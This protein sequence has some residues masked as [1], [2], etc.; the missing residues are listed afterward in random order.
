MDAPTSLPLLEAFSTVIFDV[1]GTLV[2]S[3]AAHAETWTQAFREHG[4][5]VQV[6]R[7]RSMVGMGSDKLLPAIAAVEEDSARGRAI[8]HRKKEL[9]AGRMPM[10]NATRGARALVSY[11]RQR[12]KNVV[13]ATSADDR[14][15]KAL[16]AQAGVADLMP[17]RAS[18]DDAA[19]SKPDPDIVKAALVESG[20]RANRA[21]MIGDTPYDVEA[22]RRAG[23]GA[24][25]LRCGGYWP[26]EALAG[27]VAIFDDPQA[28]LLE[29]Q[30]SDHSLPPA[31]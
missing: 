26:D 25:T 4:I 29:W 15:M 18:K 2:D 16:L 9:F 21:V 8:A 23:V 31:P 27:S 19:E 3:N 22:A 14:E 12:E 11:L 6:E 20:A 1:D 30:R 7:V 10:L 5:D 24:I 13:V 28:L 17:Q